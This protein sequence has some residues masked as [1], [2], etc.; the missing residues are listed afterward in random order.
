[1]ALTP[2]QVINEL[3]KTGRRVSERKLTDWRAR[4]LLPKLSEKGNGRGK[5]KVYFWTQPDILDRVAFV[6]DHK[7]WDTSR[8]LLVLW[9]CGFEVSQEALKGLGSKRLKR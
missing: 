8:V 7:G 6:A 9:C 2:K 5:G 1:M 3:A 4:E